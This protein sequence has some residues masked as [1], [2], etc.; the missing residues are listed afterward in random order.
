MWPTMPTPLVLLTLAVVA[1]RTAR[2]Q[3]STQCAVTDKDS[4]LFLNN[5]GL[6]ACQ[7][8]QRLRR[9]CEPSYTVPRLNTASGSPPDTCSSQGQACCCNNIAFNLA[10]LCLS[11]QTGDHPFA[12]AGT[13]KEYLNG[14][15]PELTYKLDAAVQAK[16]CNTG[17]SL[18]RWQYNMLEPDGSWNYTQIQGVRCATRGIY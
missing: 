2:G 3:D 15:S 8:Y 9:Q 17:P 10:M 12:P 13:Y 4:P 6:N 16:V 18:L 7:Q 5:D 1:S 11:C 14:C